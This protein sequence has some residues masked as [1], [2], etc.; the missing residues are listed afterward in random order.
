MH[1]FVA[2]ERE[3]GE[4]ERERERERSPARAADRSN[5]NE[6]TTAKKA[7]GEERAQF[8]S[9]PNDF[10]PRTLTSFASGDSKSGDSTTYDR[11]F[12]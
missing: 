6:R 12:N 9:L 7:K 1:I 2:R 10:H 11:V 5:F 3:A 4:R 8:A